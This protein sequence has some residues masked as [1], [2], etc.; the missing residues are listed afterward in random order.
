LFLVLL[1]LADKRTEIEKISR[2]AVIPEAGKT[3]GA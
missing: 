1:L 2:A 3:G